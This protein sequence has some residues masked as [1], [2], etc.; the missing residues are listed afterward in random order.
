MYFKILAGTGQ[1]KGARIQSRELITA[2]AIFSASAT[3][4]INGIHLDV[5]QWSA[6]LQVGIL[7]LF[8]GM[9]NLFCR[10]GV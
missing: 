9:R 8:E 10:A 4:L 1:C 3:S 7:V 5:L 2:D 6:G